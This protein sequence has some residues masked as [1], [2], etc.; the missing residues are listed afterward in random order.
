VIWFILLF[1]SCKLKQKGQLFSLYLILYS[2]GRFL[3][4]FNRGDYLNYYA[5]LT[6]SQVICLVIFP[7]GGAFFVKLNKD[8]AGKANVK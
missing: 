5:G 7:V 4:E 3:N 6:I 8:V 1:A 2:A